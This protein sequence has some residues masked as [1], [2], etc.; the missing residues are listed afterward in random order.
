MACAG[1]AQG[2]VRRVLE[3]GSREV[4]DERLIPSVEFSGDFDP[5]IL[6]YDSFVFS[7]PLWY[8]EEGLHEIAD[9]RNKL[10]RV[11][12]IIRLITGYR[13]DIQGERVEVDFA[14]G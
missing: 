4:I 6:Q 7:I 8:F 5:A 9:S 14:R 11:N 10:I 3:K 13:I 1:S 2:D 12:G